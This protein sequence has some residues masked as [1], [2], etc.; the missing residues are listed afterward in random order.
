MVILWESKNDVTR[1]AKLRDNHKPRAADLN[2]VKT[3]AILRGAVI[4]G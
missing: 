1:S 3:N 2:E 4:E